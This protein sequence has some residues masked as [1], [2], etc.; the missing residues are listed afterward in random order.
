VILA[1]TGSAPISTDVL[2]FFH[3][4][5]VELLEGYAMSESS[6]GGAVGRH[7]E[8]V[9]G[10]VGRPLEGLEL[11]LALDGEI[12][13]RGPSLMRGYRGDPAATREAIDRD[14][15]LHSGDVGTFTPDGQLTIIDRKKELIITS[16][17]KNISPARVEAELKAASPKIAHACAIGD[18]RPY[19]T[20]LLVLD[21]EAVAAASDPEA[22]VA[23]AVATA[24]RRL[25]RVEQIKRY[26]LLRDEW[27]PGGPQLTPTLK[28]RR[29]VVE[30]HF[31]DE[32]ERLYV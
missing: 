20:A 16:G 8:A 7:G 18:R 29:R 31:A 28:L 3:A 30:E 26:T 15:W 19:L 32:I 1:G 4:I 11:K 17:G 21:P 5:G 12:L 10:A 27:R 25:A 24:N 22:A 14:G 13:M 9:L 23:A 2:E 6:C